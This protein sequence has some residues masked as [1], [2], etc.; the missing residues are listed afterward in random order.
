MKTY[1]FQV[2]YVKPGT[3]STIEVGT[4]TI[5]SE[6]LPS[7]EDIVAACKAAYPTAKTYRLI[8]N[9]QNNI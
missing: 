1:K 3:F 2:R 9:K 4:I 5:E 8:R 6:S 7:H